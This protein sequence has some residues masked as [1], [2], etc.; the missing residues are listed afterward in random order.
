M[1]AK[2]LLILILVIVAFIG[3]RIFAM[4]KRIIEVNNNLQDLKILNEL[5]QPI[6][7]PIKATEVKP[8]TMTAKITGYNSSPEQTDSSPCYAGD[9]YICGRSD[10][11]AC[12]REIPKHT[13][14]KIDGKMFECL[15]RLNIRY[16]Q[17]FD[18]FCDQDFECPFEITGIKRVVVYFEN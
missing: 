12:P 10:V 18:I 11:V 3:I 16:D 4:E 9:E 6:E 8:M 2:I 15:D 13:W 17:R 1:T 7:L 14:V 5:R